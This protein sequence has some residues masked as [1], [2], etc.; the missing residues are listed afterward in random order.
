M[1]SLR[2]LFIGLLLLSLV[3]LLG[4]W[5]GQRSLKTNI[6]TDADVLLEQYRDVAK[7]V[8]N[9][10]DFL[11]IYKYEDYWGVDISPLRKK[12]LIR[13]KARALVGFDL[14]Q[15]DVEIREADRMFILSALP[16]PQIL[17]LEINLDYY[18]L[19]SGTFNSFQAADMNR[20]ESDIRQDLRKKVMESDLLRKAD[21]R[22]DL[23]FKTLRTL[24][25]RSGWEIRYRDQLHL[26]DLP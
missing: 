23:F 13:A 21:E 3:L 18:D 15:I 7:L 26:K 25:E 20:M 8:T 1:R 17:A 4:W 5:Y 11:E 24:G 9:E 19:E 16:S 22:A 6:E 2:N 12:A 14:D 10:G